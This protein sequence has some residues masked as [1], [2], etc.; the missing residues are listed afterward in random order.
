MKESFRDKSIISYPILG[1]SAKMLK[2]RNIYSHFTKS[3]LD[4]NQEQEDEDF[5]INEIADA[6]SSGDFGQRDTLAGGGFDERKNNKYNKNSNQKVTKRNNKNIKR[7]IKNINKRKLIN[8]KRVSKKTNKRNVIN[9]KRVSKKTNKRNV[10]NK[11]RVS[12]KTNKRNVINK[13]RITKNTRKIN[14]G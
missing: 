2:L 13:K 14:K 7:T 1:D 12:K 5:E 8:R 4:E 6:V 3:Q 10:I 11:K 9:K